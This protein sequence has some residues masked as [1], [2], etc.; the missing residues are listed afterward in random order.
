M[1]DKKPKRKQAAAIRYD[2]KDQ[3]PVVVA[4]G[5]GVVAENILESGKEHDIPVYQDEVL[6]E[7]LT[8]LDLGDYIPEELYKV[9]AEIM[10]FVSDLDKM[11][12]KVKR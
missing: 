10:V 8:R 9:V 5:K 11:R 1:E 7:A 6:V 4:K 3:A 12:E 2:A